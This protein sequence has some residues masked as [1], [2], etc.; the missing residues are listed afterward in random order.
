MYDF[1]CVVE[2]EYEVVEVVLEVDVVY[3][4]VGELCCWG[5]LD[6][7]EDVVVV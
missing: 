6:F 1:I 5:E 3:C 2:C 7:C 4:L